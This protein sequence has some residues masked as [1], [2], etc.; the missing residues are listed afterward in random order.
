[1]NF[2]DEYVESEGKD[3]TFEKKRYKQEFLNTMN[4][5]YQNFN[6]GFQKED[7]NQTPRV[8]FEA[9]AVGINLALRENPE[10]ETTAQQVDKLLQSVEF[11]EWTTSDA[12]NNKNKVF[13]RINGVKEYF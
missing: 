1:M 5:V 7:R 9:L 10:L 11:E 6:R 13:R 12:A 2:I 3:W 4:F 8:R